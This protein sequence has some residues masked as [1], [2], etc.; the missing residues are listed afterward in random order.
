[1]GK[2]TIIYWRD[3]PS[4][5]VAKHERVTARAQ[6][7]ERF[8]KAIDRAAMRAGRQAST[9]YL[10]DWRRVSVSFAGDPQSV[11]DSA[12]AELEKRFPDETL[13]ELIKNK[14]FMSPDPS[15]QPE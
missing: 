10:S 13:E 4:Q 9:E 6:L 14:G 8:M 7:S 3:I 5:V 11:A 15:Q 2:R 12:A 1:M